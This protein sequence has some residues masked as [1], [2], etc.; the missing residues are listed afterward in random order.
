MK[1]PLELL[2]IW[3]KMSHIPGSPK[4]EPGGDA[5]PAG[6]SDHEMHSRTAYFGEMA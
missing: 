1:S 2:Y 6:G 4:R 5:R 3:E